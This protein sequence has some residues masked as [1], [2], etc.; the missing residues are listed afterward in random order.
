MKKLFIS[1]ALIFGSFVSAIPFRTTC[2]I[3]FN[4]SDSYVQNATPQALEHTL[5]QLNFNAC[6]EFPRSFTYYRS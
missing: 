1:G 5:N 6:G 3:V 2:N 4:I